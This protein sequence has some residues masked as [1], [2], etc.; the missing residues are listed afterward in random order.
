MNKHDASSAGCTLEMARAAKEEA[1]G[2]LARLAAV[3]GVGI[4]RVGSGYGLKINLA[5]EPDKNQ[6]LPAEVQGVPVRIE[7]VGAIKKQA[8]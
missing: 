6:M 4:T 2:V 3:A 7:V 8:A 5:K 1:H